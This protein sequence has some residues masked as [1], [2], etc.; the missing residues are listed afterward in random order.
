M[1]TLLFRGKI[2]SSSFCHCIKVNIHII[3]TTINF[4]IKF[5]TGSLFQQ[6]KPLLSITA[7]NAVSSDYIGCPNF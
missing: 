7:P 2:L 5:I 4:Y 1:N 3:K 6:K